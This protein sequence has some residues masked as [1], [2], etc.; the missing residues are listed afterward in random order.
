MGA[1]AMD[2]KVY[3]IDEIAEALRVHRNTVQ[4]WITSG[5]LVAIQIGR[6]QA[7]RITQ[8]DLDDFIRRR[9]TK[10]EKGD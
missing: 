1:I 9:R 2:D 5:D 7:Y 6:R 8:A 10:K 3:T 4:S